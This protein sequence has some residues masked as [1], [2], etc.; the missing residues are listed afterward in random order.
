MSFDLSP[1]LL[2]KIH[3]LMV[4]SRV[5]EERM[6]HMYKQGGLSYFWIGGP[7][8]EAFQVPLGLLL[9]KGEGLKKDWLYLHYRGLPTLMAM[10][11]EMKEA[12]RTCLNKATDQSS[13]GR[14]FVNHYSI[15][16]WNVA[17]I[18]SVIEVQYSMAIGT[19]HAIKKSQTL[20]T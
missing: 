17:P 6:I 12:F 7:G 10:G 1:D 19:A 13:G 3:D 15:P 4:K 5:T 18:T 16:K 20:K 8:E 11:L 2:L 14:N 9:D